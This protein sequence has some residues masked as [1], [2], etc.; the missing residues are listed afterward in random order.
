MA[1]AAGEI[2]FRIML[3]WHSQGRRKGDPKHKCCG[4]KGNSNDSCLRKNLIQ[5]RPIGGQHW[6]RI[7]E[8]TRVGFGRTEQAILNRI[9]RSIIWAWSQ[10]GRFL[11]GLVRGGFLYFFLGGTGRG[12][13]VLKISRKAT[14]I[15]EKS[16]ENQLK[17]K[18]TNGF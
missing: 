4:K 17:P 6:N 14:E 11:R 1:E 18:K 3:L 15:I 9:L 7:F 13:N 12:Q 8:K 5:T 10:G 2:H 16:T